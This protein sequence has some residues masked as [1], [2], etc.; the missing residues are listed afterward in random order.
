MNPTVESVGEH[1][2]IER[3]KRR[4]GPPPDWV[5]LG[6][7]DDAAVVRPERGMVDVVTTDSLV[8]GVHF[9][10]E[11]SSAEDIGYK[12]LA[13]NLSDLAAMAAKPRTALLSLALP[14]S[15]P[16]AHFDGLLDGFTTLAERERIAL[17]GGNLTR[18]PGPLVVDATLM[19]TAHPRRLLRRDTAHAGDLLYVTG[20]LGAAATGLFLLR[21]GM[22]RAALDAHAAEC[23]A[24]YERPEPRLAHGAQVGRNRAASACVDLSDGLADAA[25]Q[26]SHASGTGVVIDAQALPV[27]PGVRA[28]AATAGLDATRIALSGGEDYELLFA[29]GPKQVRAFRAITARYGG[30]PVTKIGRVTRETDNWLAVGGR[31]E[32]LGGGFSHF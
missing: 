17:V 18:S 13:V 30:V 31:L 1:G 10:R 2:L 29:V 25:S 21:N 5:V 28:F 16:L 22:P 8:E 27:H 23:V 12:A 14:L 20:Q 9:R 7:G 32:P 6:I 19:G 15:L 4:A 26:I 24:R 3:L 11:W